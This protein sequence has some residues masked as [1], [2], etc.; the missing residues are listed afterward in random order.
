VTVAATIATI[1]ACIVGIAAAWYA[2]SPHRANKHESNRRE[3]VEVRERLSR[4]RSELTAA[5]LHHHDPFSH[6]PL[7]GM[8]SCNAWVPSRPLAIEEIQLRLHRRSRRGR[9][10]REIKRR[11]G[12]ILPRGSSGSKFPNYS[13]AMEVLARPILF[14]NRLCYPL[15]DAQ[16]NAKDPIINVGLG[17]YFDSVDETEAIAHEF[18]K[19]ASLEKP[20]KLKRFRIRHAF[21]D[22]LDVS[23]RNAIFSISALTI[24]ADKDAPTFVL[25]SREGKNVAIAG[26]L[27]HLAPSGVFQPTA[28][29]EMAVERDLSLWLTLCR[30]YAEEFLGVE[31]AL[32]DAG[33]ALSY[34]DDEPYAAINA[35][36]KTGAL[37]VYVVGLGLDPLTLCP[38][39]VT[40]ALV[41][42]VVFDELFADMVLKNTEGSMRGAKLRAGRI[43]G[44]PFTP[45]GIESIISISR[46]SPAARAALSRAWDLA[47][48]VGLAPADKPW[49]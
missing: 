49:L 38:E 25:H 19:I 5:A 31:E 11:A 44:Y 3:F 23:T 12:A 42:P 1:V 43:I 7:E 45:A 15:V 22:P 34:D 13:T 4:H 10:S 9:A 27:V 20:N 2:Y 8:L 35:A 46:L 30:E 36:Y 16:L 21:G 39:L 14:D 26:N 47:N 37:R 18:A 41:D 33:I 28:D 40:I 48:S 17:Y 6:G 32:G 29:D 24:R